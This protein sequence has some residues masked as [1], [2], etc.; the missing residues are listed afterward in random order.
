MNLL[1]LL[2]RAKSGEALSQSDI[3]W[4][5]SVIT[6]RIHDEDPYT[7]LHI[8]WKCRDTPSRDLFLSALSHEDEMVR[9]IALQ[10]LA[11]LWPDDQVFQRVGAMLTRDPSLFVRMIAATCLGDLGGQLLLRRS[12]AARALLSAFEA[13]EQERGP[14]WEASYEGMLNLVGIPATQRPP[15]TR[16]LTQDRV[17]GRVLARVRELAAANPS[18]AV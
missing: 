12:E 10:A 4:V 9:R 8:L 14:E 6:T 7:A 2:E 5:R 3:D 18:T 17:D 15:A 13:A 16:P 1:S 11:D